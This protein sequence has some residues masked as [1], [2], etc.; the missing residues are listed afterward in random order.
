MKKITFNASNTTC[1]ICGSEKL[2]KYQAY[3]FDSLENELVNIVLCKKCEFA[4]QH[5]LGRSKE[6]SVDFFESAYLDAGSEQSSY[7]DH[8]HKSQIAKLELEFVEGLPIDRKSILDVGAGAGVF[9]LEAAKRNWEVT[10]VDPAL[11]LS[12]I[13]GNEK[14]K[15]IKEAFED[16]NELEMFDIVTLWDVIEHV[17]NPSELISTACLHLKEGGWLVVETG[18]FKSADRVE[19]GLK[20][21]IYQLDHKWYF[22]PE[23]MLKLLEE[24]DFSEF[25]ISQKV[26]R[27]HWNGDADYPGP[28]I[29]YQLK[30]LFSHPLELVQNISKIFELLK[31]KNWSNAGMG[32]FTIAAK[33][34]KRV[35]I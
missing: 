12:L 20:S 18:N 27:P 2:K 6:Q 23:S 22:S 5:P 26:L 29:K 33:K 35:H 7:F 3:A 31:A 28:S 34:N 30:F 10:A 17:I 11:D 8:N 15:P 13:E 25:K 21:W 19:G 9:A 1:L 32:I 4:W 14:I 16:L 24:F